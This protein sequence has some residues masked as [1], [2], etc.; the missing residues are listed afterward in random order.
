[1]RLEI[2][3]QEESY[4]R[5]ETL[6]SWRPIFLI[7]VIFFNVFL[8]DIAKTHFDALCLGEFRI[9]FLKFTSFLMIDAITKIIICIVCLA[10]LLSQYQIRPSKYSIGGL[11]IIYFAWF[12]IGCVLLL[13]RQSECQFDE[14]DE[15]LYL[16]GVLW[17]IVNAYTFLVFLYLYS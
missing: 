10:G 1:M 5:N 9:M 12:A 6:K 14:D 13:E 4:I 3:R 16:G 8:I 2:S 15:N 11:F 7:L 17:I